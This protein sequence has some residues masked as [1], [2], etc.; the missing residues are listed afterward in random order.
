M[1]TN[2]KLLS[3]VLAVVMTFSLTVTAFASWGQFQGNTSNNGLI[4]SNEVPTDSEPSMFEGVQLTSSQ[5]WGADAGLPGV[6]AAPI[7]VGNT[8]YLLYYGGDSTSAEDGIRLAAV[9]LSDSPQENW[10]E[11]VNEDE[12]DTDNIQQLATPF[13]DETRQMIYAPITYTKNIFAG[14]TIGYRGNGGATVSDDGIV[15]MLA[16]VEGTIFVYDVVVDGTTRLTSISTGLTVPKDK[17]AAVSGRVTFTNT[18]T[19]AA[20]DYGYSTGYAGYEFCLYNNNN[21]DIPA[22]TYNVTIKINS[23]KAIDG[24]KALRAST[25]YW[26]MY[27]MIATN[28]RGSQGFPMQLADASYVEGAGQINTPVTGVT[29]NGHKYL[30]F[31]TYDGDR[32]YYQLQYNDRNIS[33]NNLTKFTP[34]NN[35]GFYW[36][37]AAVVGGNVVFGA[38]NGHVY[39]RPIGDSFATATGGEVNLFSTVANAGEVRSSICYDGSNLYLTTKNAYLWKLN[40]DLSGVTYCPFADGTNVVNASSTPVVTEDG[41]VYFGG[42]YIDW[43]SGTGVYKGALKGIYS[44]DI[45]GDN[46]AADTL[47]SA[48]SNGAVQSS[49]VVYSDNGMDYIYFTT[50]GADGKVVCV[51]YNTDYGT[52]SQ[53]WAYSSENYILQGLAVSD[54]GYMVF[55]NDANYAF[56][57]K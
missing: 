52:A 21:V 54:D 44:E 22:G 24:T 50:N 35:I 16:N 3:L 2:K 18:S 47:W 28:S 42:Y 11:K 34:A 27:Y 23:N 36:A 9:D 46:S 5:S 20:Y 49:P 32:A 6:D 25:P 57:L 15:S 29:Y 48:T 8:A 56:V 37:G 38:E 1:K 55:G 40:P 19:G 45:I 14:K 10:N 13:Y 43:S 30:Y 51:K 31:G 33:E 12:L 4:T 17:T 39:S 26:R 7:V 41:Y 53:M